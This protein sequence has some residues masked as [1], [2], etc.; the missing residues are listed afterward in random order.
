MLAGPVMVKLLMESCFFTMV[1]PACIDQPLAQSLP[2]V[3]VAVTML[4]R[5]SASLRVI[6]IEDIRS[7]DADLTRWSAM[8]LEKEGSAMAVSMPR[9]EIVIIISVNVNPVLLQNR[10]GM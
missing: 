2:E 5:L 9:I 3:G 10:A 1:A 4:L 6:I 7:N 8:K